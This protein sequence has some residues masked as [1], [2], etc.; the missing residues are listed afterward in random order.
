MEEYLQLFIKYI[1]PTIT[2]HK[3]LSIP[4][5]INTTIRN[6]TESHIVSTQREVRE[7]LEIVSS[8]LIVTQLQQALSL[9]ETQFQFEELKKK[10]FTPNLNENQDVQAHPNIENL[11]EWINYYI[12]I[13][14]SIPFAPSQ[15]L[16]S[17]L[18]TSNQKS[19]NLKE[20]REDLYEIFD[21]YEQNLLLHDKNPQLKSFDSL[22]LRPDTSYCLKNSINE[23][24]CETPFGFDLNL[25]RFLT[26]LNPKFYKTISSSPSTQFSINT[27]VEELERALNTI[28]SLKL[29]EEYPFSIC[30]ILEH[31]KRI[32]KFNI[33]TYGKDSQNEHSVQIL[34]ELIDSDL[35]RYE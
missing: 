25:A 11:S 13:E 28:Q 35:F 8:E 27:L 14:N 31:L 7:V 4:T 22:F 17:P 16:N 15:L 3:G 33:V 32:L 21:R 26:T 20:V 24:P 5:V 34:A 1:K 29:C 6:L 18:L 10:R 19:C 9:D 12:S 2:S 30:S 23:G